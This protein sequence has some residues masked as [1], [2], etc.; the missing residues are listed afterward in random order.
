[1]HFGILRQDGNLKKDGWKLTYKKTNRLKIDLK[2]CNIS[3]KMVVNKNTRKI[4]VL[5]NLFGI[6]LNLNSRLF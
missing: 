5:K 4:H 6:L 1:V 3:K 2:M